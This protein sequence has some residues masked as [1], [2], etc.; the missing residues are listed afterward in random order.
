MTSGIYGFYNMVTK[1]P[2]IGQSIDLEHRE[3]LHLWNLKRNTHP[4]PYLQ[5]SFNKHGEKNFV[6]E[7][8]EIVENTNDLDSREQYYID[9]YGI[10]NLYN[11]LP[12][13]ES[14]KNYKATEET[15]RKTSKATLGKKRSLEQRKKMSE[16]RF[17]DSNPFYGKQHT[18]ET[19]EKVRRK[20][21]G[22]FVPEETRQKRSKTM[23]G[24]EVTKE[25]RQ[26]IRDK[27]IFKPVKQI[28]LQTGEA[29][30][31]FEG[32]TEAAKILNLK[33]GHISEVCAGKRK[34]E[35]GYRWE[36]A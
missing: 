8:L 22:R 19:K 15:R 21:T 24:H 17:G 18:E 11:M 16:S 2:Y 23:M 27:S 10:D 33:Q 6:F 26:K 5:S 34:Q 29:I 28:D 14:R 1:K 13:A 7:V 9:Y 30:R 25:I 20:L 12:I 3:Y 4:N 36:Y 31:I 32:M 35:G